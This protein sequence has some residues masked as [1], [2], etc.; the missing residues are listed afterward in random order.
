MSSAL[1]SWIP[2]A[3]GLLPKWLLFVRSAHYS[4]LQPPTTLTTIPVTSAILT[5]SGIRRLYPQLHSGLQHLNLHLP[6]LQ[7]NLRR[8]ARQA[9]RARNLAQQPH[10]RHLDIP[11]LRNPVLRRLQHQQPGVLSTRDLDVCRCVCALWQRV[12][13][14]WDHEVGKAACGAGDC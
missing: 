4:P 3:E 13:C 2:Q 8:S 5:L 12:V 6:R 10:I 7:P 11:H 1:S 9:T 14:I